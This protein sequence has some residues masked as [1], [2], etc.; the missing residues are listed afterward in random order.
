ML[1]LPDVKDYVHALR[2]PA[3]T[4]DTLPIYVALKKGIRLFGE[5]EFSCTVPKEHERDHSVLHM[6]SIGHCGRRQWLQLHKPDEY[7]TLEGEPLSFPY[8]HL[9]NVIESYTRHLLELGGCP[10]FDVQQE[11][12]DLLGRVTGHIDGLVVVDSLSYLLEIKGLKHQSIEL[13]TQQGIKQATPSYYDQMQY[14]MSCLGLHA[15]FFIALDKDTSLY[16]IEYVNRDN[17]RIDFL[18]KKALAILGIQTFGE[19]PERFIVRECR[20]CPLLEKCASLE[21]QET[22]IQNFVSYQKDKP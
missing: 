8:L 13:L 2:P 7:K 20:F 17:S 18:K 22:F 15:G 6:S 16:Y 21:G 10:P 14:Y 11:V 1:I 19:I 4:R 3:P 5:Y 9:G 12:T